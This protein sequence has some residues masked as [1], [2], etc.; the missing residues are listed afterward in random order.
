MLFLR[1]LRVFKLGL[2]FDEKGTLA[3][4]GHAPFGGG[5]SSGHLLIDS[6]CGLPHAMAPLLLSKY[7][8]I[9]WI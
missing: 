7:P 9:H 3:T 4:V 6:V 5:D 1:L 2:I 8:D